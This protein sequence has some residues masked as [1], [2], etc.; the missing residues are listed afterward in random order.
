MLDRSGSMSGRMGVA[1]E[2]MWA[3]KHALDTIG[4]STTVV[5]YGSQ[6]SLLYSAS[7][8]ATDKVRYASAG[9]GTE[10]VTAL[11]HATN[12]LAD[13]DRKVKLLLNITDGEWSKAEDANEL[14]SMARRAGVLTA[15]AFISER[16]TT[17]I[18]AHESELVTA[19]TS[20]DDLFT[21]GRE[22]V[23][24]ATARNL[25]VAQ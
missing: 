8:E 11:Q 5:L 2:S 19:I 10:P 18:D 24:V 21:L 9:G 6:T 15:L 16:E 1:T 20:T 22:L 23:R 4:A 17:D 13:S 7:D 3:I 12:V 25:S 14:V